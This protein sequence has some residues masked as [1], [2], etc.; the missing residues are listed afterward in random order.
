MMEVEL[1]AS[2]GISLSLNAPIE[3][4]LTCRLGD[5]IEPVLALSPEA[6]PAAELELPVPV[7]GP[8]IEGDELTLHLPW[9]DRYPFTVPL[10]RYAGIGT[11]VNLGNVHGSLIVTTA[12]A[13]AGDA[14][15]VALSSK[16][17]TALTVTD[18]GG[19]SYVQDVQVA[20]GSSIQC[21]I[22][23][24]NNANGLA[25][26][27]TITLGGGVSGG[28]AAIVVSGLDASPVDGTGTE[29][30]SATTGTVSLT[31]GATN[32]ILIG[33]VA[34]N[35]ANT[36]TSESPGFTSLTGNATSASIE[37][38]YN[39][40]VGAGAQTYAPTMSGSVAH[41]RVCVAYKAAQTFVPYT[42]WPQLGP[43]LAQ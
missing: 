14:I 1:A 15:I 35:G 12:A 43:I 21:A 40:G 24:S 34:S 3:G 27:G 26:G 31:T 9:L 28:G 13:N 29:T 6:P 7:T 8:A 42:P 37:W 17:A 39:N 19:N 32:D 41:A 20:N 2:A 5:W 16:N 18:S 4:T 25:S 22:F 30:D 23:R 33:A 10:T 38:A 36:V 11:P